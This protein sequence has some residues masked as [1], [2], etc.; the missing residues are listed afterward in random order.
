MAFSGDSVKAPAGGVSA[1]PSGVLAIQDIYYNGFRIVPWD[2]VAGAFNP[3]IPGAIV[4]GNRVGDDAGTT[5]DNPNPPWGGDTNGGGV[6]PGGNNRGTSSNP[7]SPIA[8]SCGYGREV[9]WVLGLAW[10]AYF[11]VR[12]RRSAPPHK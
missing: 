11:L 8:C 6:V 10:V 9:P 4:N 12:R 3:P 1:Y 5:T 7:P 2:K